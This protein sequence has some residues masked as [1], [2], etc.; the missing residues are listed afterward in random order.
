MAARPD[1]RTFWRS[2]A[3]IL[4]FGLGAGLA[5]RAPGTVGSLA[6]L[7]VYLVLAPAPPWMYGLVVAAL[8]FFSVWVTG[9]AE[10]EL[11]VHDH[12]GIVLDEVVGQLVAWFLAPAGILWLAVGF[13]LFR[14]FDIW[15]PGPIRWLNAEVR[16]GWGIMLDDLAAGA[17]A[18]AC[19]QVLACLYYGH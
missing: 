10:R 2:P 12:P 19:L 7:P 17:V 14:L 18:A 16:G 5:P 6:A 3:Q 13:G 8:F 11:G 4:A 1:P 15:K 9:R